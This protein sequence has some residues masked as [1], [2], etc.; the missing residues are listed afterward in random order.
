MYQTISDIQMLRELL[1]F[2]S[3]L[4]HWNTNFVSKILYVF[5]TVEIGRFVSHHTSTSGHLIWPTVWC[6]NVIRIK[7]LTVHLSNKPMINVA[8]AEVAA[9][10]ETRKNLRR[11][12][13]ICN[14]KNTWEWLSLFLLSRNPCICILCKKVTIR[15]EILVSMVSLPCLL[16]Y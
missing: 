5:R 3:H 12:K 8:K 16:L 4:C 10:S 14:A 11:L 9:W 2:T 7:K 6:K 13:Y 1:I 15:N